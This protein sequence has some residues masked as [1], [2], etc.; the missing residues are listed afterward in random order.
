M[1]ICAEIQHLGKQLQ[2]TS[3]KRRVLN[4]TLLDEQS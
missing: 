1:A 4:V 2:R 3:L